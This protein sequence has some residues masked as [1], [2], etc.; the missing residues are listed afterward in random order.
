MT[1]VPAGMP[2]AVLNPAVLEEWKRQSQLLLN[3]ET[4]VDDVIAAMEVARQANM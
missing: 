1:S 2:H 3:G 4:T